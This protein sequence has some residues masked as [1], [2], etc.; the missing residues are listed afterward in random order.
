MGLFAG[1]GGCQGGVPS[2]L[3]CVKWRAGAQSQEEEEEESNG[4]SSKKRRRG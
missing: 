1:A 2:T 3:H 4:S